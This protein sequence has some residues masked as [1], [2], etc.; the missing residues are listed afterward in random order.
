MTVTSNAF[1]VEIVPPAGYRPAWLESA[2]LMT[3]QSIPN[4]SLSGAAASL[5]LLAGEAANLG[6]YSGATLMDDATVL[7]H[8]GG[9][10]DIAGNGVYGVNLMADVPA[11]AVIGAARDRATRDVVTTNDGY[12]HPYDGHPVEL[13]SYWHIHYD[14]PSR[15][16]IRTNAGGIGNPLRGRAPNTDSLSVDSGAWDGKDVWQDHP[17]DMASSDG[18]TEVY[19][20]HLRKVFASAAIGQS[21]R[22]A[23]LDV[24]SRTWTVL[25]APNGGVTGEVPAIYDPVR[26]R[27]WRPRQQYSTS[28]HS[29]DVG[30]S[31]AG[32]LPAGTTHTLSDPD[33][34]RAAEWYLGDSRL[35]MSGTYCADR[36]SYLLV[37]FAG[38]PTPTFQPNIYE[39]DP[40]SHVLS[41]LSVAGTP[42]LAAGASLGG[43]GHWYGRFLS[44][45]ALG[46]VL[47]ITTATNNIHF[48]RT[49]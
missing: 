17:L 10:A 29:W 41:R 32:G 44:I 5:G 7:V 13:H 37:R 26:K 16:F 9:H 34:I 33:G 22:L 23:V 18:R 38:N 48:F 47:W 4:T 21:P 46:V 39:I 27:V 3:W 35:F 43:L 42:P 45:D 49:R 19:V 28:P 8:G 11:W 20:P 31:Y 25:G 24:A 36:D 30:D 12:Y 1:R 6:A 40:D 15:R 2:P 14:A